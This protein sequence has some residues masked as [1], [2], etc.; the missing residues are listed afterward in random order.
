MRPTTII[1]GV[2][3]L[4][5][6]VAIGVAVA[7]RVGVSKVESAVDSTLSRIGVKKDTKYGN[8]ARNVLNFFVEGAVK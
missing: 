8:A 6:G 5:V 1:V 3:S 4:A 2:V 7:K